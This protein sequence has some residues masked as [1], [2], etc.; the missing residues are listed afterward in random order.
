MKLTLATTEVQNGFQWI[1]SSFFCKLSLGIAD[2]QRGF[3]SGY[4][5]CRLKNKWVYSIYPHIS[6][7]TP[8]MIRQRDMFSTAVLLRVC[9]VSQTVMM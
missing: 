7:N 5:Q 9:V 3:K 2:L 6:C 8:Q 4:S 1:S